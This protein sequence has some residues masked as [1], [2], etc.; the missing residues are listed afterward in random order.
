M[1]SITT[2]SG[3]PNII[4]PGEVR[5]DLYL[6]LDRGNFDR[7]GKTASKNIE[8]TIIVIDQAGKT[9]ENCVYY[10]SGMLGSS[11]ATLPILYHNNTPIWN[12][13]VRLQVPIDKFYHGHIRLEFRHCSAKDKNDKKLLGFAFMHLMDMDETTVKDGSHTLCLYKCEDAHR[14][15]NGAIYLALPSKLNEVTR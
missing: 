13:T 12:E 4:M 15:D 3:F 8:V 2:F 7:G 14:F 9:I 1:I 5:N 6:T 10:S 11:R